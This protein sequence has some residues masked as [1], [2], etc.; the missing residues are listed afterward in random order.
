MIGGISGWIIAKTQNKNFWTGVSNPEPK[1]ATMTPFTFESN[2][3]QLNLDG[4]SGDP[5]TMHLESRLEFDGESLSIIDRYSDG[6]E[7]VSGT[8]NSISGPHGNGTLPNGNYTANNLRSRTVSGFVRDGVGFSIDLN[9]QFQ[10]TRTLLRIHPDGN[11]AGTLGCIGIQE[12]AN[13]LNTFYNTM[14]TYFQRVS[15]SIRLIVY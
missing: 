14:S 10:T 13:L 11:T 3:S 4:T 8:W 12:N 1:L 5:S 2:N 6:S 15:N 9:P 7:C